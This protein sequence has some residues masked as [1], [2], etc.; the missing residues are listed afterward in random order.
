MTF[1]KVATLDN[2]SWLMRD[3]MAGQRAM[4]QPPFAWVM[5]VIYLVIT[6]FLFLNIFTAI[7]MD[8]YDFTARV[9]SKP[10]SNGVERQIMTFNHASTISEEWSYL[11]PKQT[12]FI[13]ETKVR[14]LLFKIG[15]PVGFKPDLPRDRQIRHL[16]RMELRMTGLSRQVH[17]VDFFISCAVLRYRLQ[18]KPVTDL[19]LDK[20]R[21]KLS[22]EIALSFPTMEDPRLEDTGGL[23]SAVQAINF[24]QGQYRGL[25]LRRMRAAGDTE[26]IINFE[27]N[28]RK[29]LER[30]AEARAREDEEAQRSM[31]KGKGKD[32][33]KK[34]KPGKK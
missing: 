25:V 4:D 21:G 8:Q 23:L 32:K 14:G 28:R 10:R 3:I 31:Q 27:E 29:Q 12:D 18:R 22:L 15:P 30:Q 24:L 11:D 16:R 6:A 1:F 5:F 34:K 2:W 19:D 9:T 33:K 7:V 26:G 13:D 20:I 17:Y